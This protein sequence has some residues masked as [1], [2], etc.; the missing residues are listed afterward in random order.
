MVFL[1]YVIMSDVIVVSRLVV[2]FKVLFNWFFCVY[3]V[4]LNEVVVF[5]LDFVNV[6]MLGKNVINSISG[7]GMGFIL[8]C[9]FFW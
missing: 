1:G 9:F 2:W 7:N 4:G 8:F 6:F 3:R 5:I